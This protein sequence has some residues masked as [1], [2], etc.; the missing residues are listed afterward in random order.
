MQWHDEQAYAYDSNVLI[1]LLEVI[2][3]DQTFVFAILMMNPSEEV[4]TLHQGLFPL[5]PNK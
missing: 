4:R 2:Q 5:P 1:A 3:C